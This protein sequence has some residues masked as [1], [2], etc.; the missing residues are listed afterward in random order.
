MQEQCQNY[1]FNGSG[2]RCQEQATVKLTL[3]G[4]HGEP[5]LDDVLFTCDPYGERC[6]ENADHAI[7]SIQDVVKVD[8]LRPAVSPLARRF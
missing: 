6:L 1:T 3:R 2:P 5:D 4:V 7:F 8:P